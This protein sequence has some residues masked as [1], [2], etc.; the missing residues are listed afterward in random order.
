MTTPT[1]TTTTGSDQ[2][3]FGRHGAS[4]SAPVRPGVGMG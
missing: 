3:A 4:R 1:T 2:T